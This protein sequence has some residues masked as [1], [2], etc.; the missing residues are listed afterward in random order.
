MRSDGGPMVPMLFPAISAN[1]MFPSDPGV[2]PN[3]WLFPV[4][5][6]DSVIEPDVV[7]WAMLLPSNSVA[8]RFLS[9]PGAMPNGSPGDE[10]MENVPVTDPEVFILPTALPA[11]SV[12]HRFPS[13]P[14]AIA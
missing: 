7:I 9:G 10:G 14:G 13:D 12:N 1:H 4:G 6:G 11:A 5:I 8:Q 2:M 3:G